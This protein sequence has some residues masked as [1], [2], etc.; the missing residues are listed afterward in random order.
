MWIHYVKYY[1]YT[2]RYKKQI[3]CLHDL[4]NDFEDFCTKMGN[5][6]KWGRWMNRLWELYI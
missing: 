2:C 1:V 6:G 4:M 5:V 3:P